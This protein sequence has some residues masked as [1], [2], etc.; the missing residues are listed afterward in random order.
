LT[1]WLKDLTTIEREQLLEQARAARLKEVPQERVTIARAAEERGVLSFAQRRL[2][3][4][5]RLEGA[6]RAY[7]LP[8]GLRLGGALDRDALRMAL[9]GIVARHEIL[10]TTFVSIDGEPVQSIADAAEFPLIEHD[11]SGARYAEEELVRL[12]DEEADALFDLE[13]GPLARGRLIRLGENDHTL[14]ITLHHIVF[15]GW[16]TDVFLD[17]LRALYEAY[18]ESRP[19]PLQPLPI[20]YADYA[21]WQRNWV[22]GDVLQRQAEFWKKLLRNAP[23]LLEL[24]TDRVRPAQQDFSG[25]AVEV[26]L[27]A[28]LTQRLR[29]LSQRHGTTLFMTLLASWAALLSRLSRQDDVVVGTLTANR[30]QAEIERLIGFFV[31]TLAL[32][33]DLSGALTVTDLLSRV[34]AQVLQAQQNADIPFERVVE[35]VQPV[36]SLAHNPLFQALFVWH[37]ASSGSREFRGLSV[38]P[39]PRAEH[40]TAKFDLSLSLGEAG[41][42]IS[43]GLEYATTLF[44]RQTIERF[45]SHWRTL[46][47][48]LTE[49]DQQA[50]ARLPLLDHEQRQSSLN[51]WNE[52]A[53]D[54]APAQNIVALFE[55]QVEQYPN[56]TAVVYEGVSL[57]YEMLNRR[58]NQLAHHLRGL[59]VKPN[60]RVALCMERGVEMI[61]SLLAVLK[62]GGGYVPLDP[63]YP[64]E[65]LAWMLQDS[66]PVAVL[67][68]G[69]FPLQTD[70]P[71][72]DVGVLQSPW[73]DA[74]LTN[75]EPFEGA[76][77]L[78]YVIYTSGSTGKPKGVMVE[79]RHVARLFSATDAW[80]RF[81]H[82]D[83]WTLFHSYAFD[84]SVWEIWGALLYGGRL[85]V[86]PQ[87]ITRSPEEFY[88]LVCRE[89]VTVLNQTPSAFRQ[90]MSAQ[91][92]S[93]EPHELRYVIFGGEAL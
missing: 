82:R 58:A 67:T 9:N 25:A 74:P 54:A 30:G 7:H 10:R 51:A 29:N 56:A 84:F 16:S 61:V 70:A 31:N 15:D 55:A 64:P 40:V 53:I 83:V 33:V 78:A 17:E 52:T 77:H 46:L 6:S 89:R 79:H 88:R 93:R 86:V 49:G 76:E 2:W 14:L 21:A 65:R 69:H 80:Y 27:D 43:G 3:F 87:A 38:T 24:P 11:L 91:K 62:A 26:A 75:P 50:V 45:L 34:K 48:A 18:R 90:F 47:Q 57:S 22:S 32:R 35:E 44:E 1:T 59:G 4:L 19:N 37:G 8:F 68:D 66:A 5:S 73:A 23:P 71:L 72:L 36:R 85:I 39:A 12:T 42:T 92:Q 63:A 20:Q 28:A 13:R 41:E 81:D 60:D